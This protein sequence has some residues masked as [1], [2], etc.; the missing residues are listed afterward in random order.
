MIVST[1]VF[2][3]IIAA[4][5]SIVSALLLR[6]QRRTRGG[7]DAILRQVNGNLV[8]IKNNIDQAKQITAVTLAQIRG[9][10]NRL[11]A[12]ETKV[13][14]IHQII[15]QAYPITTET[16]RANIKPN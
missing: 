9:L 10:D 13:T 6:G 5:G 15:P 8:P 11:K 4:G 12:V 1:T 3:S 7:N 14:Q 2:D 16:P